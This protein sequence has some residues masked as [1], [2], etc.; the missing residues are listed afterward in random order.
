MKW[1]K[2]VLHPIKRKEN[3]M[4][5]QTNAEDYCNEQV[6]QAVEELSYVANVDGVKERIIKTADLELHFEL[7]TD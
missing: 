2:A 4:G 7:N 3:S 5:F 6:A 1:Q